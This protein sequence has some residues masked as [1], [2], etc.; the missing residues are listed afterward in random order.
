MHE[1]T[2]PPQ[3]RTLLALIG[4]RP[5]AS[6]LGW[7][8]AGGTGLALRLGHR[9]SVDFDF[10]RSTGMDTNGLFE[11]LN[12]VSACETLQS[13]DRTLTVLTQGVKLSF[14][15]IPEKFLFET[16]PYSFFLVAD[17]R[18]IAL[19]KLLAI[20]NRGSRK[21]FVDLYTILRDGPGLKEYLDMLPARYGE[22]RL[23]GYQV[24]LSL[25]WFD[26]AESEP[27]PVMLEPFDWDECKSFFEREARAIVLPP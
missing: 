12:A 18:D 25:T 13:N 24:L 16:S 26:D 5:A 21:D 6:L 11:A 10:F 17:P 19:M 23:S 27:M 4:E 14:F 9:K 15:Q 8:L 3:S 7:T 22:G 20:T 1:K 2:L